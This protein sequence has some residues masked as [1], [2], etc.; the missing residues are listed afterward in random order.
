MLTPSASEIAEDR[1]PV[2]QVTV[3]AM[4]LCATVFAVF[5][6]A[7][8]FGFLLYDDPDYVTQ[9]PM[10]QQ[11]LTAPGAMWAFTTG[12]A[13]N[14]HPLTWLSHMIDC[15]LFGLKPFGH[16]LHSV[17]LHA[18]NAVLV[19]LFVRAL[20]QR[21][22]VSFVVAA[23]FALHPLRAES[24]CWVSERKDVLSAF[25]GLLALLAYIR[26]ATRKRLAWYG[27]TLVLFACSLMS[28]PMLVTL[29]ILMLLLDNWPLRRTDWKRALS[30][31]LPL[32]ALS[33]LCAIIT[34]FVQ[35][36]GG[37]MQALEPVS[38]TARILNAALAYATYL[39]Q[40]VAP[41]GLTVF[42][43]HPGESINLL[44]AL[45]ACALLLAITI[46]CLALRRSKPF[47]LWGW[48]WFIV[49]LIPA[50][51]LIQVGKQA[52][53]DRYT[54]LPMLGIALAA[55]LLLSNNIAS[56]PT[57]RTPVTVATTCL[58][59]LY[60]GLAYAQAQYWRSSLRLFAR[61]VERFPDSALSRLNLGT[62]LIQ[63][64][65]HEL[66]LQHL[67]EA[68]ALD[69]DYAL[70]HYTA[71]SAYAALGKVGEAGEAFAR[72]FSLNDTYVPGVYNYA[73][74]EMQR[75]DVVH[76][77]KLFSQVV[78]NDPRNAGALLNLGVLSGMANDLP[79][80]QQYFEL[81]VAATP[82]DSQAH[83]NLGLAL[84]AQNNRTEAI[85]SLERAHSLAP[86]DRAIADA[87]AQARSL[88]AQ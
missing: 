82:N 11:G 40:F 39:A 46:A 74:F 52:H 62:A 72:A 17:L 69:P 88:P 30:E 49:T 45:P 33:A 50:I 41:R 26:Y 23:L 84:L 10:V 34:L 5:G 21:L 18:A 86:D 61:A 78:A 24:V 68:I 36:G 3:A 22:A 16:H 6:Q 4:L 15:E 42:Y 27:A 64:G 65:Q 87:I 14:W 29:P 31:K 1:S 56:R 43:P 12:H 35:S 83:F 58:L 37:A 60:A 67:R 76:A 81:A 57:W 55:V 71:A 53:A 47:L 13:A 19:L 66:G 8:Q 32:F 73:V 28:K 79:A 54:Y 7:T 75:G 25:W 80:A 2:W 9:N 48:L 70:A 51:G 63:E 59:L 20:G 85:Q 38:F 44:V 77:Q